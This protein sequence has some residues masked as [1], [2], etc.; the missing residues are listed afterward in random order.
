MKRF[1]ICVATAVM[2]FAAT[3]VARAADM[4]DLPEETE[5]Q[6]FSEP[7]VGSNWYI[8]GDI[9]FVVPGDF[10]IESSF[11]T[12]SEVDLDDTFMAGAGF[13][14]DFG[15]FRADFT[16]DYSFNAD[17]SARRGPYVCGAAA[18]ATCTSRETSEL[19][20][21]T[22]L[23]NGYFDLGT[24]TGFT[25]YVG[26]GVG[27]AYVD[28]RSWRSTE[29]CTPDG[30]TCPDRNAGPDTSTYSYRN[31]GVSDWRFAWAVAAGAS[32]SFTP[33]LAMDVGYRLVGIEDGGLVSS[34]RDANGERV[35]KLDYKDLYEQQFRVGF[36]YTID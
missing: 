10:S 7:E 26:G 23:L 18:D 12:F 33:N 17:V 21:F 5:A 6:V 22:G 27:F 16:G 15:W 19:N 31:A 3:G 32:Y 35:G 30:G 11:D 13:G 1:S 2:L 24:W 9:G 14:Y 4:L 29:T 34:F 36:R 28:A 20:V 25:P 8:R